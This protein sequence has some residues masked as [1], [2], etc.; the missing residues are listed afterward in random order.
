MHHQSLMSL[1]S[2]LSGL[3]ASFYF[4]DLS[5]GSAL[6]SILAPLLVIAFLISLMLWLVLMFH[7]NGIN[8]NTTPGSGG[9]DSF[10]DGGG[11]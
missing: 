6:E 7:R 1:V 2:R 4:T 9:H 10:L 8:Q 5:S 3:A 11:E